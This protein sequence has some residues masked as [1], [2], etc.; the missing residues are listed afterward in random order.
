MAHLTGLPRKTEPDSFRL[1]LIS[2]NGMIRRTNK[3]G[4]MYL[5]NFF[6]TLFNPIGSECIN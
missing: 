1:R 3:V 2:P 4:I 6:V 5:R